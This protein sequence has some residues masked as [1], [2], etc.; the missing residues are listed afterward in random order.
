[1]KFWK[2]TLA[3]FA[4]AGAVLLPATDNFDDLGNNDPL[5]ANWT[6]VNGDGGG[7]AFAKVFG[8][9]GIRAFNAASVSAAYWDADV[10]DDDQYSQIVITDGGTNQYIGAAV[11]VAAGADGYVCTAFG[12]I[13]RMDNASGFS[14]ETDLITGELVA[15]DGDTLRC[16]ISGTTITR[17]V[18]GAEEGTTTD[19]TYASGSAGVWGA[20]ETQEFDDWEG[21]DLGG[22]GP[23]SFI[24]A[25]IN[26]PGRGGGLVWA[27]ITRPFKR[28]H[29]TFARR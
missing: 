6:V 28:T 26:N 22:G 15:N 1:M 19:A 8:G 12:S 3:A 24:P 21:G 13:R 20:S 10:F 17:K 29:A 25:I 7:Q 2:R 11:R 18:N 23:A 4:L 27:F 9:S 5:D 16:E 14:G